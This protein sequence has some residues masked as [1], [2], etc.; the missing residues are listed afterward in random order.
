[1]PAHGAVQRDNKLLQWHFRLMS[2]L[3]HDVEVAVLQGL[4]L[5]EIQERVTLT[6]FVSEL[7]GSEEGVKIAV[8]RAYREQAR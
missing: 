1:M 3:Q 5:E 4:T 8:E 7:P 2:A 6:G